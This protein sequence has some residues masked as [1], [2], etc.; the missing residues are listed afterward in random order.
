MKIGVC[1]DER[2][3]L[4]IMHR[5]LEAYY[6]SL[7]VEIRTFSSGQELLE[8]LKKAPFSYACIFLDVEMPEM[9]GFETAEAMQ[10]M[11]CRTPVI[12]LTSHREYA[13]DGYEV[14]AFRF[15]SKPVEQKKL[16]EAL[17]ALEKTRREG[18]RIIVSQ[19]GR[20]FFL[21]LEEILYFKSENVYLDI[22][23][24]KGHF[25][26]RKKLKEQLEEL[27]KPSFCQVHRSYIVN[28]AKVHGYDGKQIILTDGSRIPV[29]R[30]RR[31]AFRD[32]AARYMMAQN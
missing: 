27:P 24:E 16:Y 13:P 7:D 17:G 30:S 14:G 21:S 31:E 6:R 18:K 11:G 25:L 23:T 15:L 12:L 19:D 22:E 4:E 20:E 26:V 2:I 9:S 10:T 28:L 5:E 1:D 29:G 32:A 8:D 3:F